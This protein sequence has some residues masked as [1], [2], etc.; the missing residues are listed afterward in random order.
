MV[1]A[2]ADSLWLLLVSRIVQG[3]GG[4]TVGV[5]QAYVSDAME[6]KKRAQ[7][8]G[9]LSAAT[10]VGVMIGPVLGFF[11]ASQRLLVRGIATTGFK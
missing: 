6:P 5:S 3:A 1:F 10:N 9:W 4:G 11:L 7:G 8:L 2:F